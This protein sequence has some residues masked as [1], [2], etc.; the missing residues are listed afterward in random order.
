[1]YLS[2]WVARGWRTVLEKRRTFESSQTIRGCLLKA[3]LVVFGGYTSDLAIAG[4]LFAKKVVWLVRK[5]GLLFTTGLLPQLTLEFNSGSCF[6]SVENQSFGRAGNISG[7]A[8][9]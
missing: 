3:T 4:Y 1:M 6:K 9:P 5:S 8:R 7:G 2:V